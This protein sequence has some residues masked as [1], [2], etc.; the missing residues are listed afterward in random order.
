MAESLKTW[1]KIVNEEESLKSVQ[2]IYLLFTKLDAFIEQLNAAGTNDERKILSKFDRDLSV[3]GQN[4][5]LHTLD[6]ETLDDLAM[7]TAQCIS[8]RFVRQVKDA[9]RRESIANRVYLANCLKQE[10]VREI[11][12][13]VLSQ[14]CLEK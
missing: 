14:V 13:Q 4:I 7:K 3:E 9:K 2:H 12:T 5:H 10:N 11:M 8:Q 1:S 6:D